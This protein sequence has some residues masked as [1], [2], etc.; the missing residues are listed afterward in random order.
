MIS[1]IPSVHEITNCVSPEFEA[2]VT[3]GGAGVMVVRE[4]AK[5]CVTVGEGK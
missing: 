2:S 1:L 4:T 3:R 5:V